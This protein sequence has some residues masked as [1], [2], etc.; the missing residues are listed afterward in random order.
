MPYALEDMISEELIDG[1]IEISQAQFDDAMAAKIEGR[2]TIV[3]DG[4]FLIRDPAPSPAHEWQ[5]G[6]WGLPSPPAP[7]IEQA[8][9]A[10]LAELDDYRWQMEVGGADFGGTSIRTDWNSQNKIAAAYIM[11]VNDPGY[12]IPVW[13][14][15]PG[16]FA[17][18]DN[19]AIR[20]LGVAVRDHV[21]AT[22]NRKAELHPLIAALDTVEAVD[23]F[24]IAANW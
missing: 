20:A 22:F 8:V 3:L 16:V 1:G 24:D 15:V 21:Q 17:A 7:T 10:K 9:A 11:A 2:E 14:V 23:A 5:D 13:E 18:L 6:E 12:A 19:A 4:K